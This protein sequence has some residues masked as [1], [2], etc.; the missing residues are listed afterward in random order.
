MQ[1][2]TEPQ[3]ERIKQR[4]LREKNN[5]FSRLPATYAASRLQGQRILQKASG[6]SIVEWRVL[7][8]L[9]EAGPMTIRDLAEIQRIDHSQLSRALPAMR[10]KGY[11]TMARNGQDGRQ[12]LVSLAPAGIAAYAQSAPVMKQRRDAL[13]ATFT[14]EELKTFIDLLDRLE[15]FF[16]QPIDSILESEPDQ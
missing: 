15:D 2:P 6:L 5:L 8:D 11:V 7:W 1:T 12:V 14:D 16:R 13:K 4:R 3:A 10:D 9:S